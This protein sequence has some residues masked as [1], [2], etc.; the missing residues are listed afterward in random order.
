MKMGSKKDDVKIRRKAASLLSCWQDW[1]AAHYL[2]SPFQAW[3]RREPRA[4]GRR[5]AL[6][7]PY[8]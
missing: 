5:F 3:R 8:V 7:L 6:R 2:A 4:H 1:L